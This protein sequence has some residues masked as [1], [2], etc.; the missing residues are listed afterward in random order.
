M[1]SVFKEKIDNIKKKHK[2]AIKISKPK[3]LKSI[4]K[5]EE[6]ED[7]IVTIGL[8]LTQHTEEVKTL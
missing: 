2:Q 5:S 6:K 1:I 8:A 7:I 4:T 3:M